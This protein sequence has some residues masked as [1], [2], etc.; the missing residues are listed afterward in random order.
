M[1][2]LLDLTRSSNWFFHTALC[3]WI[4]ALGGER[5]NLSSVREK[6]RGRK[7][8]I[9]RYLKLVV[10]RDVTFQHAYIAP[11]MRS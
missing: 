6:G 9:V 7:V 1:V 3:G 4:C 2:V 11:Q 10:P 8:R 5:T